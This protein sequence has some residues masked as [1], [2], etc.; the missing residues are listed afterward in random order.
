MNSSIKRILVLLGGLAMGPLG[1]NAS[2]HDWTVVTLARNGAWGVAS[3]PAQPQAI[4]EATRRCRAMAGPSNDCGAQFMAARAGWIVAN[5]CGDHKLI[6]TG[7]SRI[8]AEQ[9]A[10]NREISLQ[11]FYVPHLPPCK[12]VVTVDPT[13]AIVPSNQQHLTAR[14]GVR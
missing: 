7:S 14:E 12:R 9:E 3:D 5:L 11:L 4:A 6:A 1:C 2:D 8:D 10:L 13:G